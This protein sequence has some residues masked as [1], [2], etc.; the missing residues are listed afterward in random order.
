MDRNGKRMKPEATRL[1]EDYRCEIIAKLS[2]LN[3][4]SK[5]ALGRGVWSQY[6]GAIR[7]VLD[8]MRIEEDSESALFTKT[9]NHVRACPLLKPPIY[10]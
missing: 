5:Q 3:A 8:T 7:N 2:K 10:I 4:P 1:T 9:K 6:E